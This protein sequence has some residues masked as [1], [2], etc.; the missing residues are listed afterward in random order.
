MD[1]I[2]LLEK[3][4][5]ENT[6]NGDSKR[7]KRE[8]NRRNTGSPVRRVEGDVKEMSTLH[9]RSPVPHPPMSPQSPKTTIAVDGADDHRLRVLNVSVSVGPATMT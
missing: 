5:A 6:G 8:Q 9:R 7:S 4:Q 1:R 2:S 3:G